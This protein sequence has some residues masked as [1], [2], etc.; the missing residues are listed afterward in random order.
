[1]SFDTAFISH[2]VHKGLN[3][4]ICRWHPRANITWHHLSNNQSCDASEVRQ[5]QLSF[6][7]CNVMMVN[8]GS[9]ETP[10][11]STEEVSERC[12]PDSCLYDREHCGDIDRFTPSPRTQRCP[13]LTLPRGNVNTPY[14]FDISWELV[15]RII[16]PDVKFHVR[17]H[18]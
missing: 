3:V 15:P 18:R 1:M 2:T 17:V 12:D 7:G 14:L 5:R 11:C 8:C 13:P 10:A 16:L 9:G 4:R 6:N